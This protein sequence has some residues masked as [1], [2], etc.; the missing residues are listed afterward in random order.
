M[1]RRRP[2]FEPALSGTESY[3]KD[4]APSGTPK[5]HHFWGETVAAKLKKFG[6]GVLNDASSLGWGAGGSQ[7]QWLTDAALG[8][9]EDAS[10]LGIR[11]IRNQVLRLFGYTKGLCKGLRRYLF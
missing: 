7:R 4:D 9:P 1:T 5:M 6:A 3:P 2:E 10:S 8:V 11:R